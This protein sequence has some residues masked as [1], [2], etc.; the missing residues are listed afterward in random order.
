MPYAIDFCNPAP[1]ADVNSVGQENFDWVV[2][3]AAKLAIE[4]ALDNK[5]GY[6]GNVTWGNFIK[7][8]VRVPSENKIKKIAKTKESKIKRKIKRK[9]RKGSSDE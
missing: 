2:E 1:D 5:A 6:S 8:S 7:N 9:P 4:K 3:H